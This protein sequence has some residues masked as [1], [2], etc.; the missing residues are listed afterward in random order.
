M[1]KIK[2]VKKYSSDPLSPPPNIQFVSEVESEKMDSKMQM[3]LSKMMEEKHT[4]TYKKLVVP[5]SMRSIYWKCYG[6]PASEEGDILTR[7][8]IVCLLCKTV[9]AYNRNTSNLRMHLQN[10]HPHELMELESSAPLRKPSMDPKER[11]ALKKSLKNTNTHMYSTNADGTV[12]VDGDVQFVTDP[13]V[14]IANISDFDSSQQN[15]RVVFKGENSSSSNQ[16]VAILLPEDHGGD[17]AH[18]MALDEKTL[19]DVIAEF[20]IIDFQLPD[21]VEG[22]GFQR[23]VATLRSPCEIPSK[24]KLV[25]EVIPKIYETFKESL[26]ENLQLVTSEVALSVEEWDSSS[27]ET[28]LTFAVHFIQGDDILNYKVLSTL[29]YSPTSEPSYWSQIIDNLL[30]E[31]SIKT[32]KVKAVIYSTNKEEII[33]VLSLKGFT[34]IPCLVHTLQNI[35]TKCVFH[36]PDVTEVLNKCRTLLALVYRHNNALTALR[37]QEH[38]LQLEESPL[39]ADYPK[40]WISTYAM[41]EQF[42]ARRTVFNA[43]LENIE[44]SAY[45]RELLLFTENEWALIEDVVTVLEPFKVTTM[46]LSEEKAPLISLLKPLIWQLVSSHLKVRESDSVVAQHFKT[47]L[48][49]SLTHRYSEDSVNMVLQIA[50]TLDPRFKNLP[51][52]VE[53]AKNIMDG[54]I[55]S[56][57]KQ[58]IDENPDSNRAEQ[59]GGTPVKKNR[60]SGMEFLL[61]DICGSTSGMS[62]KERSDLEIIQY[63]SEPTA[64]LDHC[65][66][67]WW[68]KAAAKCPHLAR[69]AAQYNCIPATVIPPVRIPLEYQVMYDMKRSTLGPEVMDRLIFLNANYG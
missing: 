17:Q 65:P 59:E 40:V 9:I 19:T 68:Q 38:L 16:N 22:R 23:L 27:G 58:L 15:V 6:F 3:L 62:S 48:S 26:Q 4:F 44:P 18:A 46:T 5:M 57:L 63:Q 37:I 30:D 51:N 45:D 14:S 41:L 33:T 55:K 29:H 34:L 11:R 42:H 7:V 56:M 25:E 2:T 31:W 47:S 10:K 35:C 36:H 66:L 13:N 43:V 67:A 49:E 32:E 52:S 28:Y 60:L 1:S 20:V 12:E 64:P 39:N 69:L 24:S 53:E 8:K 61:G 54:P 50:T 21:I